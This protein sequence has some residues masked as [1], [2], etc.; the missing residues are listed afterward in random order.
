MDD[1]SLDL[2]TA[3]HFFGSVFTACETLFRACLSGFDWVDAADSLKPLGVVWVNL[4]HVYVAF[5]SSWVV[6]FSSGVEGSFGS[7]RILGPG[8]GLISNF[9]VEILARPSREHRRNADLLS[10]V[11]VIGPNSSYSKRFMSDFNAC[12]IS[13]DPSPFPIGPL[14]IVQWGSANLGRF[15]L[16][17]I[18]GHYDELSRVWELKTNGPR[19]N[20]ASWQVV[21]GSFF[22][23]CPSWSS[24]SPIKPRLRR[25]ERDYRH[26]G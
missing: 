23:K 24:T 17:A 15:D 20:L 12:V 26:P 2:A 4:F 7:F 8:T 22:P 19:R 25:V 10:L 9:R 13:E 18:K 11:M 16:Q 21:G 6:F 5:C 14:F 1:S 3:K